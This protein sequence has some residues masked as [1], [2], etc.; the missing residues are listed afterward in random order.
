MA[1]RRR[2]SGRAVIAVALFLGATPG[3]K[4]AP[5][6][7]PDLIIDPNRTAG[8]WTIGTR[9]FASNDC[10]L[11]EGC[12]GAPGLRTLLAFTTQPANIS[13]TDLVLGD[14]NNNPLFVYSPCHMHYHF[15]DYAAYELA[16]AQGGTVV[17][18]H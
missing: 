7:R 5:P 12:V 4:A 11:L 14:P 1:G 3:L 18:G 8:T 16:T 6:G 9:Y 17:T 13:Q 10:V 15:A 2:P